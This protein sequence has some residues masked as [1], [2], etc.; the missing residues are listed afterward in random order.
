MSGHEILGFAA[1]ILTTV[2]W[3]PQ[4][5]RTL[6][7]K[8]T[9]SLSLVTQ[10]AFA[11]GVALWLIYGILAGNAPIILANGVTFILVSLILAMKLRYG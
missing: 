4:A 10:S 9:K 8:D 5:F 1:A 2:C 6:R 7:T 3:L 11:L